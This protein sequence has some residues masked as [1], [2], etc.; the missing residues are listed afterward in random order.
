MSSKNGHQP[1]YPGIRMTVNGN[2]AVVLV[3]T[4]ASEAAGAYPITP[5]TAMGEGWAAAVA[6][7]KLNA[8]GNPLIFVEP[9]GEHAAAGVTAGMAM[10]GLRSANFS[11]GQGIAYMHESLYAAVG[12]RLTYVLNIASRAMTK[13]TLNVHAGHDDYHAVDDTGFFQVFGKN[14]QQAADL[15]LIAHKIAELSLTPGI[16]A[17]DGFL[18]SHVLEAIYVPEPELV[19]EFLGSP[20]D[21]IECPT[22]AQRLVFGP[23]RRRIPELWDVDNPAEVGVV[24]NQDSYAQG[25]A[26]QRPFYFDHIRPIARQVLDEYAELTGRRY[27]F[28]EG[29]R[30][31][32][33]E[34]VIAGMGSMVENA[35][36]AADYLRETRGLKV[37]VLNVTFYRPFPG[38]E[39]AT[40]LM[41]KKGVAVL[42]R[43]DQPLAE[44][45]P[46][47]REVRAALDK[48][49]EN[50]RVAA[51][52][53]AG[54]YQL[55]YP[56][57]PV[58]RSLKQRPPIY[59]G[60]YGMG[61]R[62]LQ[63]EQ[64]I[65]AV[66]N[67]LP[68]GPQRRLFY[69]GFDFVD[70]DTPY[71]SQR[72]LQEE[73]LRDYPHLRE[74]SIKGS[75]NPNLLPEGAVA[76]RMHSIGGWGA[77]TT[78]L[79]LTSTIYDL[80]GVHVKA[81]PK[82]GS[83]KKGQPTAFY[84]AFA[85]ERIRVNC[86]LKTVDVVISPDPNVFKHSNPLAGLKEGGVFIWQSS[87]TDPQQVWESI[88]A[89]AQREIK[90]KGYQ[91][92][93]LDAFKIA[94][95]EAT[96]PGLQLRMQG[97]VFQGAFFRAAPLLEQHGLE[98]DAL[99]EAI[100]AQLQ[101]KFGSKGAQVVA[102]N[103][104]IVQRGFE[105]VRQ[106]QS[107][108]FEI[109]QPDGRRHT[110]PLPV[111]ALPSPDTQTPITA[112]DRFWEQTGL[113]YANGQGS[114]VLADPF[115]AH[116]V[117]PAATSVFRDMTSIRLEYPQFVLENCTGCAKCWTACP[118]MAIPGLVV[119]V[120]SLLQKA[121]DRIPHNGA[122][123][124]MAELID[125]LEV[126][127]RALLK[128]SDKKDSALEYHGMAGIVELAFNDI[129]AGIDD[130]ARAEA[131]R[132]ELP[133]MKQTLEDFPVAVTQPFFS[134][135]ER[136]NE[137]DGGLLAITVNPSACKGCME[138][139]EVC[140]DNALRAVPQTEEA[141]AQ[142]RRGWE[143]W[144]EMPDTP[145]D[146]IKIA[147]L[148]EG[149]GTLSSMLLTKR[150]YLSMNPGDGA[151]M[152]CGEKTSIHLFV[153]AAHALMIPRVEKHVEYL[154]DL[155]GRL[156]QEIRNEEE[157][158]RSPS[159]AAVLS[160]RLG[161]FGRQF[162]DPEKLSMQLPSIMHSS[163]ADGDRLARLK[164][165]RAM[166]EDLRWR[167]TEGPTGRGRSP[168]GMINNTGCTTVWGSTYPYN[169]YPF[170]WANHL[171]Q[172]GPSVA[173]GVFEGHMRKMARGFK[174]IRIAELDLAGEYDPA[175]HD[176][177]FTYF[178]W[179]HFT[180]EEWKL[181]PPVTVLGG[182]GAMLDIGFQNLSRMLASGKP[183][184]AMI[185][186]TQV[187]S[188]TGGQA[189][190]SSFTGQVADMAAFGKAQQGKEEPRKE[191]GLIA[192]MHRNTFV[193]QTS[194][195]A[196][197][198]ILQSFIKGLNSRHPAV[199]NVYAPCQPE[200]GIADDLSSRQAKL[201]LEG[202]AFPFFIYDPDAGDTFSTRFS[203]TGNPYPESDWP[204]YTLEYQDEDGTVHEMTLPFTF[205]DWAATEGRFSK[206]FKLLK[207]QVDEGRLVRFD[208]YLNLSEAER[209]GKT[210]FIWVVD[211]DNRLRRAS[212]SEALV[213]SAEDRLNLWHM[214][215]EYGGVRNPG[216]EKAAERTRSELNRE[217]EEMLAALQA[218]H[219]EALAQAQAQGRMQ[220]AQQM[221]QG[222]IRLA[223]GESISDTSAELSTSFGLQISDLSFATEPLLPS[224]GD[225]S[226]KDGG[227][228]AVAAP[229]EVAPAVELAESE[230]PM[231]EAVEAPLQ[232]GLAWIE[233]EF[234][235]TCNECTNTNPRIFAYNDNEQAYIADPKAGPFRDIVMAAEQ[236]PVEII[237]PGQP[238]DPYEDNLEQW[239]KRAEPFNSQ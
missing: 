187:Y 147:N 61:S 50:G 102:D 6:R 3:E 115:I 119:T 201:A 138:C 121:V 224:D 205:A 28:I 62:D 24:Q 219:E 39:I 218:E 184:K 93:Y 72:Q 22:P 66:E 236:C 172:D 84:A 67:M 132:S 229:K 125:D 225:A 44:D 35:E 38:P 16:N 221:A 49:V 7:G 98:Q 162:M 47:A 234:C 116:S 215:Q 188:N 203:L 59:S 8:F 110:R 106:L 103:L 231:A 134:L 10:V 140:P 185:V 64:L 154:N 160:Q 183:I 193:A 194:Q 175:V 145:P 52:R 40:A 186:D 71:Q 133:T 45:L 176:E 86:E 55:P 212:V 204:E 109:T 165:V 181:C 190:T 107:S 177:F 85:P 92:Y 124:K 202:R 213:D 222:L 223:A 105:E 13:Q 123:P 91:V 209:A 33:A 53:K 21:I 43:V 152:G 111:F 131:L 95:E 80:L 1:K 163:R 29:Y 167:Y 129:V 25:V 41:G 159:D 120:R 171:F 139:V 27:G 14:A 51:G 78:G 30:L 32:D 23:T 232:N 169:P 26:A 141:V 199:F 210:P 130:P 166:L 15:C 143:I 126:R 128:E 57:Y 114:D 207:G 151:C 37:G 5:S 197:S 137:G 189:C 101:R 99:F 168:M 118:D 191:V 11:S 238:Q 180:D 217:F 182:D 170:P 117:I 157:R 156:D 73:L 42:E 196:A 46:L 82:Y 4:A 161:A 63:P 60:S 211:D 83:E 19:A 87:E 127:C 220:A 88:P 20:D 150:N 79:N 58:I 198:H 89:Y 230:E 216:A 155:I 76:V 56:E 104:R 173:M 135:P 239:V 178:N 206:H 208:E 226:V 227:E 97:N 94:R 90:K 77:I 149:I 81:N 2:D 17:Q 192:M 237:H 74:L 136:R 158:L 68:D 174:A 153:A 70:E 179:R 148:D 233:T 9:E 48:A 54:A 122:P 113:L 108:D 195:G 112:G 75:E 96:D 69:L 144:E 18:T 31:E 36:A 146:Y 142:L 100:H 200:H 214:V 235:T 228:A 65:G 12:K 164:R 34:Y